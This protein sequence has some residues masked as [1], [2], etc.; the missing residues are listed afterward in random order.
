MTSHPP[1]ML[2]RFSS[3]VRLNFS[4]PRLHLLVG[5]QVRPMLT[6]FALE[7]PEDVL[8]EEDR[9][10]FSDL[11]VKFHFFLFCYRWFV[12]ARG[13]CSNSRMSELQVSVFF[14]R[15]HWCFHFCCCSYFGGLVEGELEDFLGLSTSLH[16]CLIDLVSLH[17]TYLIFP[18]VAQSTKPASWRK[19]LRRKGQSK[20]ARVSDGV[21]F[22]FSWTGFTLDVSIL[23]AQS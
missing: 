7:V 16:F 4:F 6:K 13:M 15:P 23:V 22:T 9:C 5:V 18:P 12:S 17:S 21:C 8:R 10:V 3:L 1:R 2:V 11:S 19:N 14:F 20:I